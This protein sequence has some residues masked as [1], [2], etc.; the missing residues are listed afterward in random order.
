[1]KLQVYGGSVINLK[2]R[3]EVY[4]TTNSEIRLNEKMQSAAKSGSLE[5]FSVSS[6]KGILQNNY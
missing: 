2:D 4:D 1:M 5:K 6:Q 3:A